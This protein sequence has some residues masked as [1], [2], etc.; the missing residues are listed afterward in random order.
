[1]M[2]KMASLAAIGVML[3]GPGKCFRINSWTGISLE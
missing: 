1:M 3:A 2:E